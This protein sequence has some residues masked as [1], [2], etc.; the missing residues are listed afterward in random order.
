MYSHQALI[1]TINT[2]E[3]REVTEPTAILQQAMTNREEKQAATERT[4][5][6]QQVM[7]NREEK[8]AATEQTAVR[9]QAMINK[10]EKRA[11]T[12]RT[13]IPQQAMINTDA[14]QVRLKQILPAELL[15]MISMEE[16][17]AVISKFPFAVLKT[18]ISCKPSL[19]III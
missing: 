5:V 3:K 14:K 2:E 1:P 18:G 15:N 4:A 6:P 13:E 17:S 9:Q 8:Q 16:K 11:V 19:I 12:E 7:T 10:E